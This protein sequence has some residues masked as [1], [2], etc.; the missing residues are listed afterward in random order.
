MIT[1]RMNTVPIDS[2]HQKPHI[3]ETQTLE[4]IVKKVTPDAGVLVIAKNNPRSSNWA[5]FEK[6]TV[7]VPGADSSLRVTL[8]DADGTVYWERVIRPGKRA[9]FV[10]RGAAG[11]HT[12]VLSAP[13]GEVLDRHR[14]R[15][16]PET[17]F[18]CSHGPYAQLAE[19]LHKM[20]AEAEG[21]FIRWEDK[22]YR[23]L[24]NWSRDH[25][26]T[27]KALKYYV[28]D[29]KSGMEFYTERPR[30]DGSFWDTVRHNPS[31]PAPAWLSEVLG[32]GYFTYDRD[33]EWILRR[34]PIE[35]D[36]EFCVA[37]GVYYAWKASGDDRWMAEQLP[38]LERALEQNTTSPEHWSRKHGL[39][40]RSFCMDSWD[41][42]NPHYCEVDH[43][44]FSENDPQ[45][46][47]HGDNSGLYSMYWR[48]AEMH[49]AL[50]HAERAAELR[51]EGAG[52]RERANNKLWFKSNYGHMIPETLPEKAVYAKV[53]DERKRMSLSTG[54][55]I[56]RGLPTHEMAVATLR[57]YQ[58]RGKAHRRESFAEWWAMDPPY[59]KEQWP[60]KGPPEGE[61][62]N[63]GI[64]AIAAGEL[65]KAA[66]DHGM[67]DYGADILRR[68]WDLAQRDGGH[69]HQVYRRIPEDHS[70]PEARFTPV[71]L[72]LFANVGLR[73][74]AHPGVPTWTDEGVNDMRNLPVGRRRFGQQEFEVIDPRENEGRSIVR[75]DANGLDGWRE[76]TIPVG[77]L[78][79]RS[80]YFMHAL[81][82]SMKDVTQVATYDVIYE[83]GTER[84]IPIR[85]RREIGHWWD[86][87]D[88]LDKHRKKHHPV[89]RETT[90]V[91]WRGANGEW[92]N[93][94]LHM[95]GWNN[96]D[97][98]KAIRA[99]RCTALCVSQ[100]PRR[101]EGVIHPE[102]ARPVLLAAVSVSDQPVSFETRIRSYGLPDCWSQAAV[103]YSI[104][105]G[106][107]G[108]EDTGRAFSRIRLSPRWS[109]TEAKRA[110]VT[111]HY[112]ASGGYCSYTMTVDDRRNRITLDLTGSFVEGEI[113]LLMP[114]RTKAK[115]VTLAG[116]KIPFTSSKIE[117]SVYTDFDLTAPPNGPIVIQY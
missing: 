100:L 12:A 2:L 40:R 83:D 30:E 76:V 95:F 114:G 86:I 52:L 59:S 64:C 23:L 65:A 18:T 94:G 32:D 9:R 25:V 28:T 19:E 29:V 51:D 63:G 82:H 36:V 38:A 47:F 116:E 11:V 91:A 33:R 109:R 5:P 57:E 66:F 117:K 53:G 7:E 102:P 97:P 41:F 89:A 49:E 96:P 22:I 110:A 88:A 39:R 3:P 27:L 84:R 67:E 93:V 85:S 17:Q 99:I 72:R 13:D 8:A 4:I 42:A 21:R 34:I 14:F 26:Y 43:R 1:G 80:L 62:M 112:P 73:H 54:Y 10:T 55:T 20:M 44:C 46:L 69:L 87:S 113:H 105:E 104:A 56:N 75:L 111:L 6:G 35:A 98:D 70:E 103:Y 71:D 61:Y 115:T 79:G 77:G 78:K 16:Q 24:M 81:G 74:G 101:S 48:L 107:A 92:K 15:L 60:D 106:L 37:E 58:R 45:F 108:I 50:G 90:R 31:K 68:I